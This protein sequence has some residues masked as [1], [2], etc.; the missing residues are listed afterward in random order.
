M[1]K[2]ISNGL[3]VLGLTHLIPSDSSD[4]LAEYGRL[5]LE[6]NQIMN[7]TAIT[8]PSHIAN[9]HMLDCAALIKHVDFQGHSLIDIGT[10]AGFPGLVLKILI[11]SLELILLDSLQKRLDWLETVID[12]LGL[13]GVR[14]VHGRGEEIAHQ[15]TFRQSFD[16]ATARAVADMRLLAELCLPFVRPGGQFLAMKSLDS[17]DELNSANKAIHLLGGRLDHIWDYELPADGVCHRLIVIEKVNETPTKYPRRWAKL[18]N[19]PL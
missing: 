5:L 13:S 2:L 6:G 19:S 10:G 1:K 11:P 9:L 12:F 7:L 17:E 4:K 14:T 16:F 18:R 8:H 15:P 3:D